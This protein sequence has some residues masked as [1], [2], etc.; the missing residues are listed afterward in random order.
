MKPAKN[1]PANIFRQP[2]TW[3]LIVSLTTFSSCF[4]SSYRSE[5]CPAMNQPSMKASYRGR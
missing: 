4:R 2:L 1:T 3:L 5:G